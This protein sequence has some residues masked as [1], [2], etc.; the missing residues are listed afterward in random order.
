ML[1]STKNSSLLEA[2]ILKQDYDAV[3]AFIETIETP[4]L[5]LKE[6]EKILERMADENNPYEGQITS[7]FV[8]AMIQQFVDIIMTLSAGEQYNYKT[9][10][11]LPRM[12]EQLREINKSAKIDLFHV[13]KKRVNISVLLTKFMESEPAANQI[14]GFFINLGCISDEKILPIKKL[15]A[16]IIMDVLFELQK[17]RPSALDT[18]SI[19][20]G[21]GLMARAGKIKGRLSS[22]VINQLVNAL[23]KKPPHD[24][25]NPKEL[26]ITKILHGFGL[27]SKYRHLKGKLD[28]HQIE[29]MAKELIAS[30]LTPNALEISSLLYSVGLI[31]DAN[32]IDEA[33]SFDSEQIKNILRKLID[34]KPDARGISSSLFGLKLIARSDKLED[35]LSASWIN[36]LLTAL[37]SVDLNAQ[38]ISASFRSLGL[39]AKL[40]KIHGE[41][42][43]DLIN[44]LLRKLYRLDLNIKNIA[45]ALHGLGLLVDYGKIHTK[46]NN[47]SLTKMVECVINNKSKFNAS[48]ISSAFYG[49]GLLVKSGAIEIIV[50][51]SKTKLENILVQ[52]KLARDLGE[53]DI[54]LTL[55]S[56]GLI[57]QKIKL[58]EDQELS[59]SVI[60]DLL[61]IAVSLTPTSLSISHTI[62]GLGLI[63]RVWGFSEKLKSDHLI[64]ILIQL[65]DSE[66]EI[67]HITNSL[68]G[69]G[70]MAQTKS[71]PHKLLQSDE[72]FELR[73]NCPID[74]NYSMEFSQS[75]Q[76]IV[77]LGFELTKKEK[78]A[79]EIVLKGN[80][81]DFQNQL[82]KRLSRKK[83]VLEIQSEKVIGAHCVDIYL[84]REDGREYIIE[85]DGQHH[86]LEHSQRIDKM[87][88][89][90]LQ[91]QGFIVLRYANQLGIEKII[92][93]VIETVNDFPKGSLKKRERSEEYSLKAVDSFIDERSSKQTKYEMP[94]K[95]LLGLNPN[96]LFVQREETGRE[97]VNN[98]LI[99]GS[100]IA[101]C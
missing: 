2:H 7:E 14:S 75:M 86:S 48:D 93:A 42:D 88:D 28:G 44:R 23:W 21:L 17:I 51:F 40:G 33:P 18:S 4:P 37:M 30:S 57:S 59:S 54:P 63:A 55:Y 29:K 100:K 24:H 46:L 36:R 9:R 81:N 49:L 96:T 34:A 90:W 12:F 95:S 98:K 11:I 45:N 13:L 71:L 84:K 3:L 66:P 31:L 89:T 94:P 52:L 25:L 74:L 99:D 65:K 91:K 41:L 92:A 61:E 50:P 83:W 38:S 39:L 76:G 32:K 47:P 73:K 82:V 10:Q 27:L 22:D 68:Y 53:R 56:L 62:Y 70:L 20:Y 1:L 80:P 6:I 97:N 43:N 16:S 79:L 26:S 67:Q 69:L 15:D 78:N 8:G 60:N 5:K 77:Y 85:L 72:L 58:H 87:R 101:S 35:K 19:L 64:K